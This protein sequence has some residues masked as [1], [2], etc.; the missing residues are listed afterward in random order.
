MNCSDGDYGN[1]LKKT[2]WAKTKRQAKTRLDGFNVDDAQA[3]HQ[4]DKIQSIIDHTGES[5][6]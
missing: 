5:D 4:G 1:P 3:G 6:L 2:N